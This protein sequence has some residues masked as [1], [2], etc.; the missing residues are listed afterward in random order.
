[1]NRPTISPVTA[2]LSDYAA[3]ARQ[4]VGGLY[5]LAGSLS[6]DLHEIPARQRAAAVRRG[7]PAAL[8]YD[9]DAADVG[10]ALEHAHALRDL[11]PA[12]VK[13]SEAV[14]T[15]LE[16]LDDHHRLM[17]DGPTRDELPPGTER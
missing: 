15:H 16:E 14:L 4:A 7:L 2:Q 6:N 10:T 13:L 8:P 5:T 1:M 9:H 12:L 11:L 17:I 3:D